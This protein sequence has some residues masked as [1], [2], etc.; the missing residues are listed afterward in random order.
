MMKSWGMESQRGRPRSSIITTSLKSSQ[1]KPR[2][3]HFWV[4]FF[5]EELD[6]KV[7]ECTHWQL[8]LSCLFYIILKGF[9]VIVLFKIYPRWRAYLSWK[10][11]P[12]FFYQCC[13]CS[14]S[15]CC[16]CDP[17]LRRYTHRVG[18]GQNCMN[19]HRQLGREWTPVRKYCPWMVDDLLHQVKL[20]Q[21]YFLSW[22]CKPRRKTV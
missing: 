7:G 1:E 9:Y 18:C 17:L 4:V 20:R 10:W 2:Q 14:L 15:F 6:C 8:T 11:G 13:R 21:L 3:K 22:E 12:Y 16:G 19:H 5:G